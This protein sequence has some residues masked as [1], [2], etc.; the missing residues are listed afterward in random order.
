MATFIKNRLQIAKELLKQRVY[1]FILVM[2]K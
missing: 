1:V 2:K